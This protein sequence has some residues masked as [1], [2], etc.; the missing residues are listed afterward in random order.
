M[1]RCKRCREH[2]ETGLEV[3]LHGEGKCTSNQA[4]DELVCNL[5]SAYGRVMYDKGTALE[6]LKRPPL[7]NEI[8]TRIRELQD[9]Y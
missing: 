8:L 7:Y 1:A 9:N 6:P 3:G 4:D 5:L 2:I